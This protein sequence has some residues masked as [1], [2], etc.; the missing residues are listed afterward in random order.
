MSKGST[1]QGQVA[2]TSTQETKTCRKYS[3]EDKSRIVLEG[4]RREVA[5]SD[6]C[7]WEGIRPGV[8]YAWSKDTS[9]SWKRVKSVSREIR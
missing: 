5:V 7:R 4:F 3:P 9:N 1:A 2:E 8:F 6:F